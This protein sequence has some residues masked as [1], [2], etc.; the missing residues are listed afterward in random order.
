[1]GEIGEFCRDKRGGIGVRWDEM[2]AD[3]EGNEV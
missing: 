2:D 1:M 3:V